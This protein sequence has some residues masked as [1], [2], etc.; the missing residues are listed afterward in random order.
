MYNALKIYIVYI[1]IK[2]IYIFFNE[3]INFILLII[4][5]KHL[6]FSNIYRLLYQCTLYS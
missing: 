1:Y 3:L 5:A 6:I 2:N 4:F